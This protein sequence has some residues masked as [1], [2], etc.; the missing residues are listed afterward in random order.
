MP[1]DSCNEHQKFNVHCRKCLKVGEALGRPKEMSLEIF[2][3]YVNEGV[4]A[5]GIQ[6]ENC[7]KEKEEF[8]EMFLMKKQEIITLERH[9]HSLLH[10][11]MRIPKK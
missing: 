4:Q 8:R 3:R 6:I 5:V 7:I 11:Q 2:K 10:M 9:H 1:I